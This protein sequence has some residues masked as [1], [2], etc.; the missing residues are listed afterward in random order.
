MQMIPVD[1]ADQ[2]LIAE[3]GTL[4]LGV[5]WFRFFNYLSIEISVKHFIFAS[6]NFSLIRALVFIAVIR[7]PLEYPLATLRKN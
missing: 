3:A 7:T 6:L 5:H 2:L 1:T 4:E